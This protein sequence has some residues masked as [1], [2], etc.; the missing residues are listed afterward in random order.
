MR[1]LQALSK[2]QYLLLSPYQRALT[3][4][5]DLRQ[6][7]ISTTQYRFLM[8]LRWHVRNRRGSVEE[9]KP[10]CRYPYAI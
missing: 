4:D 8:N 7:A 9:I 10:I 6:R 1:K 5:K 2:D 3:I